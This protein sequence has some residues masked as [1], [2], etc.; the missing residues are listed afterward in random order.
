VAAEKTREIADMLISLL[1]PRQ[2]EIFVLYYILG[3]SCDEIS[4]I[5]DTS[6]ANI[7]IQLFRGRKF[8]SAKCFSGRKKL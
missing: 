7:K 3:H 2:R 5:L 6:P 8:L 1:P 4:D